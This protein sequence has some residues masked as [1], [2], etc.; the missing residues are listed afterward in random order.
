M[1]IL[2]TPDELRQW[3]AAQNGSIGFVPT[4]GHL[5]EGHLSLLRAARDEHPVVI[6]SIFLNP[7]Q[8]GSDADLESYPVTIDADRAHL[9]KLNS[10]ALFQPAEADIYPDNFNT[11]VKPVASAGKWEDEFRPGH[12]DGVCT[13]IA[14][15]FNL[16]RPDAAYFGEKDYQQLNVVSAMVEDLNIPVK[17]VP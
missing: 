7:L 16:V 13:V 4:L 1:I 3:R 9:E 5:H 8:F 6:A 14:K 10:D 11:V 12:F 2:H 17:I 15:L